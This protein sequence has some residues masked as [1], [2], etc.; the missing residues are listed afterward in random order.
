LLYVILKHFL[1]EINLY[2]SV[3]KALQT[4]VSAGRPW[5]PWI[6]K[7]GTNTVDRGL[8]VL[9]FGPFFAIFWSFRCPPLPE[10]AN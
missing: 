8:K 10:E 4:W 6:F 2:F 7:Y 9:F 5:P 3:I 1:Y